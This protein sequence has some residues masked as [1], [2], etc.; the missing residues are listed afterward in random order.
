MTSET[1]LQDNNIT[2]RTDIE[3]EALEL[4]DE[5][6]GTFEEALEYLINCYSENNGD[7]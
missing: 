3:N 4:V 6:G 2:T 7:K 1:I 5:I